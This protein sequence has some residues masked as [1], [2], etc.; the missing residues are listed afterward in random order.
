MESANK[1]NIREEA[2]SVA[3]ARSLSSGSP[4]NRITTEGPQQGQDL[5]Y[6]K[7][8]KMCQTTMTETHPN[9]R[10]TNTTTTAAVVVA[11]GAG[12]LPHPSCWPNGSVYIHANRET[13]VKTPDASYDQNVVNTTTTTTLSPT[14]PPLPL[15]TVVEFESSLFVGKMMLRLKHVTYSD[16]PEGDCAYFDGRK[17]VTQ[18]V[19]QGQFKQA[20]NMGDVYDGNQYEKPFANVPKIAETIMK[21]AMARI[22]PGMIMDLTSARPKVLVI[23]ASS[24]QTMRIDPPGDE[25]DI[26][27]REL[28]ENTT[29]LKGDL[30]FESA[31]ERKKYFSKPKYASQHFYDPNLVYTFEVYQDIIDLGTYQIHLPMGFN[32]DLAKSLNGQPLSQSAMTKQGQFIYDFTIWHERLL[33]NT[34]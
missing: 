13:V 26:T 19:V 6:Q 21:K 10:R 17:R 1:I 30:T 2:H 9:D 11:A 22:A 24:A 29:L 16:N 20:I 7:K 5:S 33:R 28:M 27:S 4:Q 18:F 3:D 15:G 12:A 31:T 34:K 25:P 14:P 23:Q 32:V 8:H